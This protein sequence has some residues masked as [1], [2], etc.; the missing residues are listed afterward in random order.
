MLLFVNVRVEWV[1]SEDSFISVTNASSHLQMYTM[2]NMQKKKK[3]PN[4]RGN[5]LYGIVD[6]TGLNW[7]K[8]S[9]QARSIALLA[10]N[11]RLPLLPLPAIPQPRCA[12]LESTR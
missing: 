10:S 9:T 2:H 6:K 7:R 4:K 1:F 8:N 5:P 3:N 11:F 12:F